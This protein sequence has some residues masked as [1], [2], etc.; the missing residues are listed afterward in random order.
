MGPPAAGGDLSVQASKELFVGVVAGGANVVSGYPFDTVKV[1]LQAEPGAYKGP[2]HCFRSILRKEGV[3]RGL[4]RGLTPPLIGGS[5]ETGV[6]Y[7]VYKRVLDLLKDGASPSSLSPLHHVA[8]AA[9]TAGVALSFVLGP[10][11]LIK[12]RMQVAVG[13]QYTSPMHCL[14]FAIQSE[15]YWGLTRGLGGTL[16]REVPGNAIF[17]TSYELLRRTL[18]GRVEEG[19]ARAHLVSLLGDATSAVMCGGI[20]GI[21]MWSCVLPLDVAKTRIQTTYPGS[22]TD[23]GIAQHLRMMLLSGGVR[24]LYAGLTPTLIRAFPANAAQ[25]VTWEVVVGQ[26]DRI[27]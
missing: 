17:F 8:I 12:C 7:L 26:L 6:N 21:I 25:W 4:Y 24:A 27:G 1:R 5:L 3:A 9:G 19:Q 2:W 20:A 11:E 13:S 18:P 16:A 22:T 23:V 15:G 10:A 14:R